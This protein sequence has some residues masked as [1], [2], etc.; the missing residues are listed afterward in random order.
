[1]SK[2]VLLEKFKQLVV[3]FLDELIKQFPTE[4]DLVIVRTMIDCQMPI[5]LLLNE[6]I[7]RVYPFR[8][9]IKNRNDKFFLEEIKLFEGANNSKVVK[10]KELW[11]SEHLDQDNKDMIWSYFDIFIT[12]MTK[13]EEIVKK[14]K[15]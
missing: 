4:S 15:N 8:E 1:M 7:K 9:H 10:F 5:D 2:I 6:F 12:I 3:Q 14:E 11:L 13:Y